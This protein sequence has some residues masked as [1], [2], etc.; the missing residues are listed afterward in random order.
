MEKHKDN[1]KLIFDKTGSW[2]LAFRYDRAVRLNVITHPTYE[3]INGEMIRYPGDPSVFR[4][5]LLNEEKEKTMTKLKDGYIDK[6]DN[7]E[8]NCTWSFVCQIL[9]PFS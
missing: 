8:Y 6:G 3:M 7:R 4:E 1:V 5:D 2:V 9:I